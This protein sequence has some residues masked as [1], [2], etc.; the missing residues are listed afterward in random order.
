MHDLKA[1]VLLL[2]ALIGCRGAP[3]R[4]GELGE[5]CRPDGT[6]EGALECRKSDDAYQCLPKALPLHVEPIEYESVK[7][8]SS[9]ADRC[10]DAGIKECL[11]S[12]TSVWGSKPATCSCR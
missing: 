4:R 6:C 5:S 10:G 7:F 2:A 9:C 12:D 8:C 3:A 1:P 11:Y